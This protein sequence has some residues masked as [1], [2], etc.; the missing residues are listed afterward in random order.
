V[1]HPFRIRYETTKIMRVINPRGVWRIKSAEDMAQWTRL[2][3]KARMSLR[4]AHKKAKDTP[5]TIAWLMEQA[6]L[7][8][9]PRR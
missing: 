6:V 4:A 9:R 1:K 8:P 5:G 2:G 7:P 3:P